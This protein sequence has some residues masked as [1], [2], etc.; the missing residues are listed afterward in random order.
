MSAAPSLVRDFLGL[1]PTEDPAVWR[2]PITDGI[3]GGRGALY[4][5]CGLAAAI[6]AAEGFVDRPTAWATLQF[7]AGATP[8]SVVTLVVDVLTAGR[9]MSQV[10]VS[11][12]DEAGQPV[13]AGLVALGRRE[14]VAAGCWERMPTVPP[15]G[16]CPPRRLVNEERRGGSGPGS[17]SALRRPAPT[18]SSP[19]TMVGRR[20]GRR[21]P[22]GVPASAGA[23]AVLGDDV[24]AGVAAAIGQ[25]VRA[26]SIDNTIRVVEPRATPWVLADVRIHA[27]ADGL[28]HG[29]G[30][31]W[32]EDGH[33]LAVTSQTGLVGPR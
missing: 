9:R 19:P 14:P 27:V 11:G 25:D 12:S 30:N 15:P 31:L 13:L 22:G 10:R 21:M 23:L 3:T 28:G 32:T 29:T 16:E 26:R 20:C 17:T 4:G 6:E 18:A 24:S 7:A 5:G 8:P 33:L 1:E 2:L